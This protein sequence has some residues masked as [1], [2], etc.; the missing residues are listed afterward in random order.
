MQAGIALQRP[1]SLLPPPYSRFEPVAWLSGPRPEEVRPGSL[2]ALEVS[3]PER[4][5]RKVRALVEE[6][7]AQLPAVP[8]VLRVREPLSAPEALELGRQTAALGV[9]AV[10]FDSN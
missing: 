6:L 7:R 2:L 8:L 5:W 9:R 4:E 10:V 1:L 3:R